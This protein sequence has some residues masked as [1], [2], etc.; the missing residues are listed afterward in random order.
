[1]AISSGFLDGTNEIFKSSIVLL[2]DFVSEV[3][4]PQA[5]SAATANKATPAVTRPRVSPFFMKTL[6]R[7]G[8]RR[9]SQRAVLLHLGVRFRGDVRRRGGVAC[10]GPLRAGQEA[11][12]LHHLHGRDRRGGA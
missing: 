3:L 7:E 9:R 2:S 4:L 8:D 1:M 5:A 11:R 12:A 6:A 10:P